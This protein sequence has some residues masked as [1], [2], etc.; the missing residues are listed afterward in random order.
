MRTQRRANRGFTFIELI[1]TLAIMGVLALVSVPMAQLSYQRQREHELRLALIEI[2]TAID[3]YKRASEQGRIAQK[4]GDSGYPPSLT[5]L[6]DGVED[7]RSPVRRKIFFL[8]RV[9]RDPM[10]LE[11][12]TDAAASW[13]LRSYASPADTPQAGDDVYD[14][15][16]R[17]DAKGLNGVA[18]RSW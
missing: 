9:P 10:A 12:G 2:R 7:Q 8:R 18:Y 14:V 1:V 17:S 6:V 11:D 4:L 5:V 15:Y 3:D 13:G 16:S